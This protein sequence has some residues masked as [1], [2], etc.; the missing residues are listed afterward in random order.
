MSELLE[1]VKAAGFPYWQETIHLYVG[2]SE[3]YGTKV[4]DSHDFDLYGV[5]VEPPERALGIHP[6]EHFNHSTSDDGRKNTAAD[7]DICL[8]GLRHWAC[9]AC[10]GNPTVISALFAPN[11]LQ[12]PSSRDTW[13]HAATKFRG[14]FLAQ[15]H[16]KAFFG[17]ADSQLKRM[18]NGEGFNPKMASHCIRLLFECQELMRSGVIS[19]PN[20]RRDVLIEIR[21]G[22]WDLQRVIAEAESQFAEC[23]IAI[24]NSPLPKTIDQEAISKVIAEA[25]RQH[26][27]KWK[28]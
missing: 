2:G 6:F 10:K 18:A 3:L 23:K 24:E 21:R 4:D 14:M 8:W 27:Q 20:P 11:A 16:Y 13:F 25:Y 26:W 5:F 9:L 19:F 1:H 28:L 15:S 12:Q 22:G 17:Y 7:T